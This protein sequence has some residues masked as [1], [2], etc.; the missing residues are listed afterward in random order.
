VAIQEFRS[1]LPEVITKFVGIPQPRISLVDRDFAS[2]RRALLDLIRQRFPKEFKDF[3]VS[4]IGIALV[5]VV[6][7]SH[8]QMSFYIDSF[9]NEFFFPTARTLTGMRRLTAGLNY[10]M[11]SATSASVNITAFPNP[12]QP[13][14]IRLDA[15]T[16]FTARNGTVWQ[17]SDTVIIDENAAAF[18]QA[19]SSTKII[20]VEGDPRQSIFVSDGTPFQKLII[21]DQDVTDASVVVTIA[22]KQWERADSLVF[23]EGFGFESDTI[24][25]PGTPDFS[26]LLTKLHP[27]RDNFRVSVGNDPNTSVIFTQ[28]DDFLL[29]GPTDNVFVLDVDANTGAGTVV[30]GDDV[31]GAI[32]ALDELIVMT[33]NV[34]GPQERYQL[35]IEPDGLL[36]VRFGDDK[37]A[38]IPPDGEEITVDYKVGGGLRGNIDIGQI[39]TSIRGFL[40]TTNDP[41]DVRLQNQEAGAGGE[42]AETVDHARLFA[43][44]VAASTGRAVTQDDYD[45]L[46]NTFVHPTFGAVAFGKADLHLD[47]PESNQVDLIIWTRDTEG[48]VLAA[49]QA[50]RDTVGTFIDSRADIAHLIVTEGG[51]TIHVD[52]F[53]RVAILPNLDVAS[54]LEEVR[55]VVIAFFQSTQVLPG[56]DIHESLLCTVMQSVIGVSYVEITNLRTSERSRATYATGDGIRSRYRTEEFIGTDPVLGSPVLRGTFQLNW[57]VNKVVDDQLGSLT[58]NTGG[59]AANAIIYDDVFQNTEPNVVGGGPVSGAGS[60][61]PRFFTPFFNQKVESVGA[62]GATMYSGTLV[63]FDA[64]ASLG[65]LII[66]DGFQFLYDDGAGFLRR[67]GNSTIAAYPIVG[68][69]TYGTGAFEMAAG[70]FASATS[71]AVF[72][73]YVI[74][75]GFA[76]E[77]QVEQPTNTPVRADAVTFVYRQDVVIDD[78]SGDLI[79][80][81]DTGDTRAEANTILY[82][83]L[84]TQAEELASRV[85]V[86]SGNTQF[87]GRLG[88]TF[89]F[90]RAGRSVFTDGSQ[91]I[92]D[93]GS[94]QNGEG[95]LIGDINGIGKNRIFYEDTTL[96]LESNVV[97]EQIDVPVVGKNTYTGF[98]MNNIKNLVGTL[99]PTTPI[100]IRI[101]H[102]NGLLVLTDAAPTD[103]SGLFTRDGASTDAPGDSDLA[104]SSINYATGEVIVVL[105][106]QTVGSL[107]FTATYEVFA[108]AFN[109]TFAA[110]A[111]LVTSGVT[112]RTARAGEFDLT[113]DNGPFIGERF[114]YRYDQAL[115]GNFDVA[116]SPIPINGELIIADFRFPYEFVR[117]AEQVGT[118]DPTVLRIQGT[119]RFKILKRGRTVFTA[120][121]TSG[122]LMTVR[123]DG[124]SGLKGA[125]DA[126]IG[127]NFIDYDTG[128]FD[129]NFNDNPVLGTQ[130]LVSYT[131]VLEADETIPILDNQI[132]TIALVEL[133]RIDPED[134]G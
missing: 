118:G 111:V 88:N 9:A 60:S 86:G 128:V 12:A 56:V 59:G 6:A 100:E 42:E 79:G 95:T 126:A 122:N 80:A 30:F 71:A 72:A 18:P 61:G 125:V 73:F 15:E 5:D 129:F 40:V 99:G 22:A 94:V 62:A 132:A 41:V 10:L 17:L 83:D 97:V 87:R 38:I 3:N 13:A 55:Q 26:F 119:T 48:R 85:V 11:R 53:A 43:P 7:Y 50:F 69:I 89:P 70:G 123:D 68:S 105:V 96:T 65:T 37:G 20:A 21:P 27:R 74:D 24:T 92:T 98:L 36:A 45:A 84:L 110:S 133:T 113:L 103:F 109:L 29:S 121:S 124:D 39:D 130:I 134:I 46:I 28:V 82:D 58:G 101:T 32:P 104:L 19:D 107:Q 25:S 47:F 127:K 90:I 66:T 75:S 93:V 81:I 120:L 91:T 131:A 54:I 117:V 112:Y 108:G 44:K 77:K 67:G 78:G 31:Q 34:I 52:V 33:Y 115:G 114:F 64:T 1:T 76:D 106:A 51:V 49:P 8:A 23:S 116:L 57:G 16:R 4:G 63:D 14:K 2:I 35:T 102:T